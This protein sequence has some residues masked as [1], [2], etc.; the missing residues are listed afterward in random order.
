[1]AA[2]SRRVHRQHRPSGHVAPRIHRLLGR[3]RHLLDREEEPDRERERLEDA[4]D[5]ER[6]EWPPPP[7]SSADSPSQPFGMF[8]QKLES[9]L[10]ETSAAMKKKAEH[11]PV[12]ST[13]D[14]DA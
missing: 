9:N 12:E 10:P 2:I 8:V 11:R 14:R 5:A 7:A 1:M 6:E 4:A 3:E 13:R